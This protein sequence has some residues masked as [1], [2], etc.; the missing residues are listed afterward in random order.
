MPAICSGRASWVTGANVAV[1][2]AQGKTSTKD[3]LA[4]VLSS[5]APTTATIGSLNNELGVP[6]TM[7]RAA[8]A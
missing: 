3:L 1:D 2:G 5:A 6:L 7:L 8:L 4:A